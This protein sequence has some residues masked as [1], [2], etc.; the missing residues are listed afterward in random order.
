MLKMKRSNETVWINTKTR[1]FLTA[2]PLN[3][4]QILTVG[5]LLFIVIGG[6]LLKLPVA[7]KEPISWMDAFFTATSATT[8]T[9]L[10]V[11]DTGTT[12][13]LFG[14]IVILCLIQIGGLGFMTFAILIV[15]MLGGKIGL[16]ERII[17]KEDLQTPIGGIVRLVKRLAL[18]AFTIEAAGVVL[19]SIRWIPDMGFWKGFY[20]SIF[21]IIAAFNNAGFSLWR[22]NLSRYVGDPAVNLIITL[23]IVFGGLGFTVM[24]DIWY[25]K[26][27]R[28]LSLHSKFMI[29]GTIGINIFAVLLVYLIEH[30]NPGTLG[31]L[32][33]AD[34]WWAAYFQGISPR[35]AGFN[36]VPVGALEHATLLLTM[37][38]MFIGAGSVSTGGGI[39]LTT[40]MVIVLAVHT[41]LRKK[42]HSPT[43]FRRTIPR[44]V[45]HRSLAITI[46]SLT[47]IFLAVFILT[48]T[49]DVPFIKLMFEVISAFGTVGLS[50]GI[51]ASL[52]LI[53]K[54]V[55]MFMMFLG[56]VG[57][58]TIVMSIQIPEEP[59][60]RYPSEDL[61]TG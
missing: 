44:E 57:P 55:L 41:F 61:I 11:V 27:F 36:T 46:T 60:V 48:M 33:S 45:V 14:Q 20:Y 39:K 32:S 19:L 42:K 29:V 22:D 3:P 24:A 31:P 16:T 26:N 23:M 47:F 59:K 30:N 13:T 40:F 28:N 17:I 25:T 7:A 58:L 15:I 37:F 8:V 43:A 18:F 12:Y 5:F 4:P 21:H 49:E 38:L 1:K 9:G 35:T 6:L 56:L 53:G 52:S 2:V 10:W 50:T 54:L 51:T 34:K